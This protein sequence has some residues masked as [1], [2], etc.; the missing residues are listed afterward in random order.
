VKHSP[1]CKRHIRMRCVACLVLFF[2]GVALGQRPPVVLIDGY[3]LLCQ[4]DDLVSIKTFGDLEQR[5]KAEG[6]SVTY[7]PTCSLSGKPPIEDI[8]N[9]LAAIIEGLNL[10]EVD[11][12]THSLGGLVVRSYLSGK[13]STPGVFTPPKDPRI[14]KWVSIATPNFGALIPN[15]VADFG[16]D[17]QAKELVPESQFLFDLATWNQNHD[18]L[19][20]VDAVGIIGN[21]GG[22][23]PFEGGSDGTVAVTSA[24]LSFVEP[25]QRTRVVPYCHG[26]SILNSIL[27]FGCDAPP[28]A[29][30]QSDNPL[31][32]LIIDSFLSGRSDWKTAGH[33]PSE[34]QYLSQYGGVLSQNRDNMDVPTGPIS[35]QNFVQGPVLGTYAVQISK[36]GPQISLISP[37]A[38]RLSFL[39]LAPRMLISI[40]GSRLAGSSVS[41][42][43]QVLPSTYSNDH[44]INTL[45][46]ENI[47]GL[48]KLTVSN[49]QGKATVNVMIEDAVPAL[50]TMDGSGRGAAAAIRVGN[51]VELFL[52]GLGLGG[53]VPTV[54]LNDV[55]VRVTYAGPAP[56]FEGLDQI[57]VELPPDVKSGEITVKVGRRASN[58]VTI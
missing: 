35:D 19:R 33:A 58:T 3:H 37:S 47:T 7:L 24:S 51:Y 56:G 55:P 15:F 9:T 43:G 21:A 28:L 29:K 14:R 36:P 50:F 46:P 2:G 26:T 1:D 23:G 10:S 45:L 27:G 16:P 13:Q 22:F 31:S 17:R 11:V 54:L 12:V 57:N 20:G 5:L 34:D 6:V 48:A 18:D 30:I 8:G 42:N 52:T 44:Q 41:V 40:Y 25:D 53:A 4:T 38:A 32:W 39:S 49:I